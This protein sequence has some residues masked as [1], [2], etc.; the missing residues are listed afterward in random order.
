MKKEYIIVWDGMTKF[1]E[2]ERYDRAREF[3]D[4]IKGESV[5]MYEASCIACKSE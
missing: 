5:F 1:R 4:A 2:F 3:Y